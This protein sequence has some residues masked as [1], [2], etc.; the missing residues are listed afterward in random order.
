MLKVE[1]ITRTLYLGLSGKEF[2]SEDDAKESIV[3]DTIV[4]FM[5]VNG[6]YTRDFDL[7]FAVLRLVSILD[8]ETV[9]TIY[10]AVK[11]D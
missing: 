10:E 11:R 7:Q 6:G 5:E 8:K 3:V 1:S 9:N 2:I 4:D